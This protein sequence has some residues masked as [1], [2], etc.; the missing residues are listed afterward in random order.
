MVMLSRFRTKM[1]FLEAAD[2]SA[3][4]IQEARRYEKN[5]FLYGTSPYE[6]LDHVY[7]ARRLLDANRAD[8]EKVVGVAATQSWLENLERYGNL[9]EELAGAANNPTFGDS[10]RNQAEASLR[11]Y[12]ATIL[13]DASDMIVRERL[14]MNSMIRTSMIVAALFLGF[15]VLLMLVIADQLARQ[16][17]RPVGILVQ[18][19]ERIADGDFSPIKPKRRYADEFST[20][21]TAIN[22]MLDEL[23]VRQEQL[24]QSRKMAAVGTLTSGIA[25]ELNN[26]LNNI[27]LTVETLLDSSDEIAPE[28]KLQLLTDIFTQVQRAAATVRNLLDF[29]RVDQPIFTAVS[30]SEVIGVT[31][32]LVGNEMSLSDVTAHLDI[33][34]DLP[35]VNG[36]P[37]NLQQ[38]FLNL[39]LN[40][41]QAMPNGGDLRI[42]ATREGDFARVEIQ[43]SGV[44]IP[45]ESVE[46]IFEPFF[47]TKEAGEGT[48]LGLSVSYSIIEKHRGRIEVVSRVGEGT[49]FIVFIP[50]CRTE[51]G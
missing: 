29:T 40:A 31:M 16:V 7:G 26:P 3:F 17:I 39:I 34:H 49:T 25:H 14:S 6:A 2:E 20:L 8:V 41:V 42:A 15:M 21:T 38:V 44:G 11:R 48:G 50:I 23:K 43:D 22:K 1:E 24:L 4:E 37:R 10:A 12:G 36:N 18:H 13:G 32:K 47:T 27:S 19:V 33:A 51:G 30:V 46:K 45:A 9:L 5:F 28:R 35:P